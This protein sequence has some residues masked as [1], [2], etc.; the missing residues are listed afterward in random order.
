[1]P[2]PT[3]AKPDIVT[4]IRSEARS[5]DSIRLNNNTPFAQVSTT[6]LDGYRYVLQ[7]YVARPGSKP[8]LT[9]L[10]N[11]NKIELQGNLD[12]DGCCT[13]YNNS[14]KTVYVRRDG[15][16]QDSVFDLKRTPFVLKVSK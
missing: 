12:G 9:T 6:K 2:L 15:L 7:Y 8:V 1:M 14:K 16:A 10:L 13:C 3:G 5:R 11:I 4:L